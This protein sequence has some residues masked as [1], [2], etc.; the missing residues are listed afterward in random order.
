MKLIAG[1][2]V[3]G[4]IS[5]A[6]FQLN[7]TLLSHAG[8][9]GLF[10]VGVWILSYW[11]LWTAYNFYVFGVIIVLFGLMAGVSPQISNNISSQKLT[12]RNPGQDFDW[13]YYARF[14]MTILLGIFCVNCSVLIWAT[15]GLSSPFVPFY[16]MVFLLAFSYC[17]FPHPATGV[18][19]T[20]AAVF[21][22][23]I[24]VSEVPWIHKI[25]PAPIDDTAQAAINSLYRRKFFEAG[26]ITASILV[27]LISLYLAARRTGDG[28]PPGGASAS[29]ASSLVGT[30][31]RT[32]A[33]KHR[34]GASTGTLNGG[35]V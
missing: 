34:N 32:E 33:E 24:L 4:A 19:L 11:P 35:K 10:F 26:F 2:Q 27:P 16:I 29:A 28:L 17:R 15:G 20:F 18:T 30:S 14:W 1:R 21:V 7:F 5:L 3:A 9:S 8:W 12:T 22:L 6:Q 13:L 23:S 25:I 31:T